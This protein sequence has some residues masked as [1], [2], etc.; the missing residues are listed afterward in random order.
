MITAAARTAIQIQHH[1]RLKADDYTLIFG[2]ITFIACTI[3]IFIMIPIIYWFQFILQT[4]TTGLTGQLDPNI[5]LLEKRLHYQQ[6]LFAHTTLSWTTIF[7][8]KLTFILF[9]RPVVDQLPWA[10][11]YWKMTL[12]VTLLSFALSVCS[13]YMGCHTFG[14]TGGEATLRRVISVIANG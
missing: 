9:F 5:E 11:R 7:S 4:P 13:I 1:R 6:I 8:I 2:C 3:L 14:L 10:I 12:A